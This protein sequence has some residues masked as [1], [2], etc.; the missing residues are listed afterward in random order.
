MS[1]ISHELI[2]LLLAVF[3]GGLIG[4]EREFRDKAAGFRT[5]IFICVGSTLF[6]TISVHFGNR[7]DPSR[8]A[9]QIVTG[10]G[11]LGAGA[12]LRDRGRVVGLTTAA[13]IWL[14]AAIGMGVGAGFFVPSILATMLALLVLWLFPRV[15]RAIN[16][17]N[18]SRTYQVTCRASPEDLRVVETLFADS[19]LHKQAGG[20][21]KKE[22]RFIIS[23][24]G[25]GSMKAHEELA[26][27]LAATPEVIG[28]VF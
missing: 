24:R 16:V 13:I 17:I 1:E 3:L 18:D 19:D 25:V 9:A 2:K 26:R 28:F 27:R 15:E 14:T 7:A 11:F 21:E 22:G 6:T 8:I 5:V 4:I 12:I 10:V 23:F 20:R